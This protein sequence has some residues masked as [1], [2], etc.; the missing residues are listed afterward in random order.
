MGSVH[1]PV[2]LTSELVRQVRP[3]RA[4]TTSRSPSS[5]LSLTTSLTSTGRT[6]GR[7]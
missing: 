5:V 1:V 4:R 2:A 7:S 6:I 3:S